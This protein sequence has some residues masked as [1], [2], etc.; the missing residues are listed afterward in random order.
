MHWPRSLP[1]KWRS[2]GVSMRLPTFKHFRMASIHPPTWSN[3]KESWPVCHIWAD[4]IPRV[5]CSIMSNGSWMNAVRTAHTFGEYQSGTCSAMPGISTRRDHTA[6]MT[7][8]VIVATTQFPDRWSTPTSY[9]TIKYAYHLHRLLLVH[10]SSSSIDFLFPSI[11][12]KMYQEDDSDDF[13]VFVPHAF[14]IMYLK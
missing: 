4:T 2:F 3:S 9:C 14:I 6:L 13:T 1:I 7:N 8:G 10:E 12:S 11:T 5:S